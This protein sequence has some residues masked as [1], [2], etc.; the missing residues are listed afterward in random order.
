M[1]VI[2]Y[3]PSK[4][5]RYVQTKGSLKEVHGG[6]GFVLHHLPSPHQAQWQGLPQEGQARATAGGTAR[7]TARATTRVNYTGDSKGNTRF[8]F[9]ENS[10]GSS[11]IEQM[12]DYPRTPVELPARHTCRIS[13]LAS[14]SHVMSHGKGTERDTARAP[15]E[16]RIG[17]G[18]VPIGF[19]CV[20]TFY[21]CAYIF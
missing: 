16:T 1:V 2:G 15:K 18:M 12:R 6:Q 20:H 13:S 21:V 11:D 19:M 9:G 8:V 4:E 5:T 3:H 14:R 7:V 10:E 17:Y